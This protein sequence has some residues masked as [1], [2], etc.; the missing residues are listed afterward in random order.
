MIEIVLYILATLSANYL[1]DTFIPLPGG[2][3]VAVGTLTFGATFT[4][5]DHIHRY[6]RRTA[7]ATI[8][9]AAFVNVAMAALLGVPGRIIAASFLAIC[10][11]E[12][13]DTE[14]Y[15]RL[16]ARS[17]WL[18]VAGSNAVS[19]PLDTVL[20]TLLAFAGLPDFP[21]LVLLAI[22]VGDMIGKF[23]IGAVMGLWNSS[24]APTAISAL[25]K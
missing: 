3:L 16:R 18:R 7:Y 20:F 12:A 10:L 25:P 23:A 22:I 24:T 5:R 6:G 1:A 4:L 13:A 17:W 8:A 11:A 9:A 14:V 2:A 15:H 21:P 19:I